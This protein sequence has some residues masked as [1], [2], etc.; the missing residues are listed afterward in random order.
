[1]IHRKRRADHN[2]S[3]TVRALQKAGYHVTDLSGCGGGIPDLL[4]TK[5]KYAYLIEIKNPKGRNRFTPQQIEYYANV[6]LPVFVL[7]SINDVESWIKGD[8][9]PINTHI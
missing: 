9:R 6:Q 7:R 2:Q 1:M 3:E 4:V 5:R 8:I